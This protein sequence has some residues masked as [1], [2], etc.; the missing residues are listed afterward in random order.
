M[1]PEHFPDPTPDFIQVRLLGTFFK[2]QEG[3]RYFNIPR[4]R[5]TDN[6]GACYRWVLY[7]AFFNFQWVNVLAACGGTSVM[8]MQGKVCNA[9]SYDDVLEAAGDST[10]AVDV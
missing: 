3:Y 7:K 5:H 6:N 9:T 1:P 2:Q 10:V 8:E 4:M